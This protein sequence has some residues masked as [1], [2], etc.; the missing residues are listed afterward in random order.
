V[1]AA[2]P[3]IALSG[4]FIVGFP[5]ETEAEFADT[6][7]LIDATRYAQAFSFKYSPRPGTPAATMDDQIAA[8]IMDDRLKRLQTAPPA[9]SWPSIAPRSE[10]G[11]RSWSNGGD[12]SRVNGWASR[13][14]FNRSTLPAKPPS[15]IW[16]K[17]N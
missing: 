12:A 14:G 15:A 17:S 7:A 16:S 10:S 11:A 8:E 1:R 4:D 5:G 9:T 3:D 2:R 13:P 6:L